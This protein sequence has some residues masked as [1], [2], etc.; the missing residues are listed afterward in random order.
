MTADVRIDGVSK[1]FGLHQVFDEVTLHLEPGGVYA[2]MAPSG[3]GKTTLLRMLLG[4]ERPD[5]GTITGTGPGEVSAMFQEERLCEAL[6]AVENVAL[7]HPDRR[8]ARSAIRADLAGILPARALDQPV[9]ELSGG[10]RRRVSLAAAVAYPGRMVILD[11]PFTGLDEETKREVVAYLQTCR[12][13]RTL[14]VTT[15]NPDDVA[16]LGAELITMAAI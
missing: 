1:S 16:L 5:R 11:E 13:G 6:T 12:A 4:L 3:A 2:L 9:R 7:L 15:H 8:I 10:M 14:L